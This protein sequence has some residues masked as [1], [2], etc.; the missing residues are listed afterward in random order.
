MKTREEV[1]DQVNNYIVHRGVTVRT[2]VEWLVTHTEWRPLE[3]RWS[4]HKQQMD[5]YYEGLGGSPTGPWDPLLAIV[6]EPRSGL[7]PFPVARYRDPDEPFHVS[8]AH[9]W[10]LGPDIYD[11]GNIMENLLRTF[12]NKTIHLKM[13]PNELA[14]MPWRDLETGRIEL[15][16]NGQPVLYKQT[17]LQL[18]PRRDPIAS[19]E[20]VLAAN[21]KSRHGRRAPRISL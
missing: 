8:L 10:E 7:N 2:K 21:A 14:V 20:W 5:D 18:D 1:F 11:R 19:S 16:E 15:G 6:V 4:P 3:R 9:Y 12:H 13:D 17:G